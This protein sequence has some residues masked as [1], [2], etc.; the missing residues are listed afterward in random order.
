MR[1]VA[2]ASLMIDNSDGLF[3]NINPELFKSHKGRK[4]NLSSL[5]ANEKALAKVAKKELMVA[6][7]QAE[8]NAMKAQ[9]LAD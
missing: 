1:K 4:M 5:T 8:V 7:Y 9:A 6:R 3:D 2:P